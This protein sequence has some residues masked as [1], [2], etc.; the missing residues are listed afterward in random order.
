MKEVTMEEIVDY[1]WEAF[2]DLSPD[3]KLELQKCKR[4]F[5]NRAHGKASEIEAKN[6]SASIYL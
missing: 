1:G 2:G 4:R 5:L 6:H 3:I